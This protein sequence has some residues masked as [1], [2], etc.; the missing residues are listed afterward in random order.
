MASRNTPRKVVSRAFFYMGLAIIVNV[1]GGF[2]LWRSPICRAGQ[3]ISVT[4]GQNLQA[5]VNE[6][7][8]ATTFSLAAGVYRFQ[9]VVPQNYDSF[10]GQPGAILSG[11]TLLTTF[12]QSGAYWMAQVQ[13]TQAAS[14]PG[15]CNAASPAC[16]FPEDLF[17]NNVPKTRVTSLSAVGPGTWYLDY[18]TGTVYMGDNPAGYTVEVSLAGYAFTGPAVSVTISNLTI[19]KYASVAQT[20]AVDGSA[21]TYWA[22]EGNE[23][24][25]NH[26]RGITIG[27]GMYIC[28]NNVHNNGQLGMGGSGA[29]IL[30][31]SNQIS[32]NNYAGYSYYWE[33]GGAE[34]YGVQNLTVQYNYSHDNAGPGFWNDGNSQYVTYN[35][36]QASGNIEAAILSEISSN[37]TIANNYIW[38]DGNNPNGSGIW[39]GAGILISD[40]STVS[41]TSNSISNCMNGIGEI[42][43]SRGNAP[44]GQPY[45]LQNVTVTGNT[46]Y[47]NTGMAA[48]I[49][50]EG[51]GFNNSVYTSWNNTFQGNTYNL[52][53]PSGN[54][55]YWLGQ[56]MTLAAFVGDTDGGGAS[57]NASISPSSM[58]FGNCPVD[59]G[60]SSQTLTLS[61]TGTAALSI[62]N[63]TLAG[64]N[65]A[66][67][68]EN[69]T[70]NSSLAAGGQ[71]T[72]AILFTP[73]A[74]G[75]R[76]ASLSIT[77]NAGG[78][79]QSATLAGAGTHDVMLS[80]TGT[81]VPGM[82]GYSVYR[83]TAPNG[84][85]TTALNSSPV[86]G[87]SYTD[88]NVQAGTTYYY[89]VTAVNS[90]G[91][92]LTPASN[93]ASATVP[94][95]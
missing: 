27:D 62:M 30:V 8:P 2:D 37:I 81:A 77:D 16:A 58:A 92:S 47:Q 29:N 59:E 53:N 76:S 38:D 43:S 73:S 71:C 23:I 48:G 41:V 44:N 67:F 18:S 74:S 45:S 36:N 5:L 22:L 28:N 86:S 66:D 42:L 85:S 94:S 17:F 52:A 55:F 65:P 61:N 79:P 4:P 32:Y 83:G 89:V 11:A 15:Q 7:P 1:L 88:T 31:Q 93:E 60:C 54:Y 84:E 49:V 34:F 21:S 19:E 14:Y 46:I 80:W 57:P 9:S 75:S 72:V 90:S 10:V 95:P 25:Y 13:V 3:T 78:S 68:T 70:C 64:A 82:T 35:G 20:G 69:T 12:N 50:V 6:Y 56:T 40:S 24:R 39:W 33:A 63:I 51:S 91:T 87:T 26:G